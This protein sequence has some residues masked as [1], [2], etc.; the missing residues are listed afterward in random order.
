LPTSAPARVEHHDARGVGDVDARADAALLEAPDLR[1]RIPVGQ[2]A[3][4]RGEASRVDAAGEQVV[5]G[6]RGEEV[7]RVHERVLHGCRTPGFTSC[8]NTRPS[9]SAATATITK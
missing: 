6:L 9:R 3:H 1:T 8:T 5:P 2:L 4:A 7:R